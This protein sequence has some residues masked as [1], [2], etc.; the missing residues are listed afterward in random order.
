MLSP[1]AE[2]TAIAP[3]AQRP[4]ASGSMIRLNSLGSCSKSRVRTIFSVERIFRKA[5]E[6]VFWVGFLS[7]LGSGALCAD[8]GDVFAGSATASSRPA[9]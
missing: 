6:F 2:R 3:R 9:L 8:A 4:C 7:G 5:A 1:C